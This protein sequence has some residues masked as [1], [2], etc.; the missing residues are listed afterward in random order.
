MFRRY[1]ACRW[2]HKTGTYIRKSE[3]VIKDIEES[4][5]VILKFGV[6]SIKCVQFI[7]RSRYTLGCSAGMRV[8]IAMRVIYSYSLNY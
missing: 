5:A 4:H 8:F 1:W 6:A 3:D 2:G 7:A